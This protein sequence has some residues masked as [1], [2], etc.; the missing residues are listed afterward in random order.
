MEGYLLEKLGFLECAY[1]H[2]YDYIPEGKDNNNHI[3]N[4]QKFSSNDDL[5]FPW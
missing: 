2:K 3:K 4:N 1:C 5:P